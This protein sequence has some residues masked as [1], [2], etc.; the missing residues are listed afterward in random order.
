M[1]RSWDQAAKKG[2]AGQK[3]KQG[4]EGI[5][6]ETRADQQNSRRTGNSEKH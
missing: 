3:Q 5:A 4:P 2:K 6:G 1:S